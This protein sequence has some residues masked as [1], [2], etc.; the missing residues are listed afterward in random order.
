M[1]ILFKLLEAAIDRFFDGAWK[2]VHPLD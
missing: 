1:D 2:N